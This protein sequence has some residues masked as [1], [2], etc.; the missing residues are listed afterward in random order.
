MHL[1]INIYNLDETNSMRIII[2][3]NLK[4]L[5]L[6]GKNSKTDENF[7]I[8]YSHKRITFFITYNN[9]CIYY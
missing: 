7:C 2:R 4:Y 6:C 5:Q 8:E 1:I 9:I 3:L